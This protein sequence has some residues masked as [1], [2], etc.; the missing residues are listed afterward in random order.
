MR[1][2]DKQIDIQAWIRWSE[3]LVGET[4]APRK[5]NIEFII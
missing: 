1:K 2:K 3:L 5:L 4:R